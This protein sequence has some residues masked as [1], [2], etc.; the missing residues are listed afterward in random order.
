MALEAV[1]DGEDSSSCFECGNVYS[2]VHHCFS[3]QE[4]VQ[5]KNAARETFLTATLPITCHS[6]QEKN[7]EQWIDI[8]NDGSMIVSA[9]TAAV[10]IQIETW[11]RDDP[12]AKI[13]IFTQW[14]MMIEMI[15]RHCEQ[16]NWG[17]CTV[18]LPDCDIGDECLQIN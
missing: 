7:N 15:K 17:C 14:P 3:L 8:C 1:Q 5:D 9:K 12:K 4:L 6:R 13:I 11:L 16:K 2:E 10:K 18:C